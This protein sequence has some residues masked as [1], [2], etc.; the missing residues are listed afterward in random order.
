MVT[1]REITSGLTEIIDKGKIGL[2]VT[3]TDES[4][5]ILF[6][7]QKIVRICPSTKYAH[8]YRTRCETI[9]ALDLGKIN[10]YLRGNGYDTDWH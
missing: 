7:D 4:L 6:E 8:F 3:K 5:E 9:A 1:F 10:S 2:R